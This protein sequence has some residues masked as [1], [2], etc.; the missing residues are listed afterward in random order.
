LPDKADRE[1]VC[2]GVKAKSYFV[3]KETLSD[4]GPGWGDWI[5][6][7]KHLRVV[8]KDKM[9]WGNGTIYAVSDCN[10]G[11][12]GKDLDYE[13]HPMP[14]VS[15]PGEEQALHA[16]EKIKAK[17]EKKQGDPFLKKEWYDSKA[18][19]VF[20][21]RRCG[22]TLVTGTQGTKVASEQ[23]RGRVSEAEPRGLEQR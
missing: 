18:P 2:I 4:K 22:K 19:S 1:Y 3:P 12:I 6:F 7:N 13:M 15:Y 17:G 10:T 8:K 16:V 20:S 14:K 23:L 9:A 11:A 5:C 21:I